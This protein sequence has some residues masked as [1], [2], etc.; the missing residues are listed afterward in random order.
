MQEFLTALRTQPWLQWAVLA[1]LLASVAC[2]VVGTYVVVRRIS[3]IAGGISHCVLGGIGAAAYFS[4]VCGWQWLTPTLGAMMAALAAAMIIGVVSLRAR[5]RVDT[6]IGALWAVGMAAGVL[7]ISQTPGYQA[8]L[9]SYLL[10]EIL[11]VRPE[12][13]WSIAALDVGILVIV[14]LFYKQLLAVCFDEEQARVRGVN[15]DAYYLLLLALTALTVV[16]LAWVVGIVM[17]IALLTLPVAIAG[18]F[19]RRLWQMMLLAVA[20]S[21]VFTLAGQAVSWQ[22]DFPTGATIILLAGAVYLLVIVGRRA[23]QVLVKGRAG[24]EK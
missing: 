5:E 21:M 10:G 14:L 2:G 7:F 22:L 9:M 8:H 3:Y 18:H 6:V 19:T 13:V 15:V 4:T 16:L 23:A 1:G 20:L 24:R 11:L 12:D 17:V